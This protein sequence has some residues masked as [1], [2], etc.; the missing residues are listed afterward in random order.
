MTPVPEDV[1]T[2][3]TLYGGICFIAERARRRMANDANVIVAAPR[4]LF[5]TRTRA[6][7]QFRPH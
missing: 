1:P 5:V 3:M 4:R 6:A 7:P 2:L